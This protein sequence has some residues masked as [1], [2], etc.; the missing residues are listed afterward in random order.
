[1][2][3]RSFKFWAIAVIF[4]L[5]SS[6]SYAGLFGNKEKSKKDAKDVK[7][8]APAKIEAKKEIK[9]TT[10]AISKAR[11]QF[12][13]NSHDFGELA[14]DSKVECKFK[15]KNVGEDILKVDHLQGTCKCT[16]P[17]LA[18][19]EYNPG[20]SGEITVQFHAPKYQGQT[21]Q[22]IIVFSNDSEKPRAELE[23]KAYVKLAVQISPENLNLSLVDANQ[24][25]TPIILTA[26]DNEKFA[27]TKIESLGNVIT[28]NFDPND[29]TEKHV[30]KP[31]INTTYLRNNLTGAVTF[32][33]NH[34][35]CK[36][37]RLQWNCLKEFEA[38]PS[39]IILRNAEVGDIQKRSIFLTSNY[40]QPIT[41]DSIKSD[42]G[43]V[44]VINQVQ[45]ENRFQFDVEIAPP[46]KE[47]QLRV[48]S[49][50]LHI[51]IKGKDEIN[52]PCRGFYKIG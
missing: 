50:T 29:Y 44:K 40:N 19:K 16:I 51:K 46:A 1:M 10:A 22:H 38:S 25:T 11:I 8:A 31:I 36:D 2:N 14:P 41:I 5:I 49:D 32:T 33:I 20:E 7:Q 42:K 47:G 9:E 17:D 21:S 23:I 39:V 45:T 12:D 3:G 27:I 24:G 13:V 30:L 18:K 28:F 48:F 34:P 35:K 15:F 26:A 4:C 52:I 43:I 37:V 6:V